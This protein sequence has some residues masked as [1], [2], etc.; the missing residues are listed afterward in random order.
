M[1]AALDVDITGVQPHTTI[2][3]ARIKRCTF[4]LRSL[5]CYAEHLSTAGLEKT[6]SRVNDMNRLQQV[7]CTDARNLRCYRWLIE[8]GYGRALRCEVI[9]L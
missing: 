3:A 5:R 7:Q 9:N 8:R 6:N 1:S 2:G 4:Y